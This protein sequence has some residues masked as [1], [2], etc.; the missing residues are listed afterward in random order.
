ML[1][2]PS[3]VF[4]WSIWESPSEPI[5]LLPITGNAMFDFFFTIVSFFGILSFAISALVK[6]ISRS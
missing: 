1:L 5:E 3:E 4:A 6:I 2:V